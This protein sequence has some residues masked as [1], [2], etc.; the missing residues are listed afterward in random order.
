MTQLLK[1]MASGRRLLWEGWPFSEP[2]TAEHGIYQLVISHADNRGTTLDNIS[3]FLLLP[4]ELLLDYRWGHR[5]WDR[6]VLLHPSLSA[7]HDS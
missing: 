5:E 1:E 3:R 7:S 6:R 4:R 2:E